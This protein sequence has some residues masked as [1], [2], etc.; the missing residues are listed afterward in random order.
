MVRVGLSGI[1]R[2]DLSTLGRIVI[3]HAF[4][5]FI[6]VDDVDSLSLADS[7]HRAFWL[8]G[9]AADALVGDFISH[10]IYLLNFLTEKLRLKEGF[11]SG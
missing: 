11:F 6:G 4:D 8:A 3:T 1:N 7:L 10:S 9:P 2:A 5:A